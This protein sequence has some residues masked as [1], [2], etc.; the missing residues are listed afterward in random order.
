MTWDNQTNSGS[1][2]TLSSQETIVL[3]KKWILM[4]ESSVVLRFKDTLNG[5]KVTLKSQ[6]KMSFYHESNGCNARR[7]R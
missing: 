3:H 4:A 5:T 6:E 2:A 1:I 7:N